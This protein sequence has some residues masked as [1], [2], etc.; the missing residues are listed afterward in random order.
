MNIKKAKEL[1]EEH[2]MLLKTVR[3]IEEAIKNNHWVSIKSP[4]NESY[5]SD[6]QI[7]CVLV[8]TKKRINE[9]EKIFN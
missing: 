8:K 3:V 5:L 1:C 4:E 6:I 2:D 7:R 9:I